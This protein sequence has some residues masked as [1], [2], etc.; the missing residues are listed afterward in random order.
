[1][2]KHLLF[3]LFSI[4]LIGFWL[5]SCDKTPTSDTVDPKTA[6]EKS[7]Q[8]YTEMENLLS[9]SNNFE[10]MNFSNV[11][12]LYSE[13]VT[14][15]PTNAAANFGAAFSH[16]LGTFGDTAIR[17]T[18]QRWDGVGINVP[19]SMV[20]FGIPT[21]S[22]D[23]TLPTEL[24][25]KNLVK[26]MQVATSDPPT[27]T[28]MQN[29]LRDRLLPRIN[30]AI[31]R[32]A[33]VETHADFELRISGKMQG[34]AGKKDLYL[35]L[36]EVY[37]M[38]AMLQGMKASVEQF[39]VFKF[40][41]SSYT[42]KA[43]VTALKQNNPDFFVLASDGMTRAQNV[44]GSLVAAVGKIRSGVTFLKNE[45]DNQNDDIIKRG[46]G[47][48]D[49]GDIDST[50]VY[51]NKI[52]TALTGTFTVELKNADS[53]HNN[54]TIQISLN[55]FYNNLPQN[56]KQEWFP[57]YSVDST[58]R[59]KL[60]IRWIGQDY[61]TFNF[62]DPTFSGLFPGMTNDKLKRLL[63]IDEA[64]AWR[65]SVQLYNGSGNLDN[66]AINIVVNG[67]TYFPKP[68]NYYWPGSNYRYF[69]FYIMDNNSMAVQQVNT[70][71]NGQPLSLQFYKKTPLVRAKFYD[72]INA[73]I[74]PASQNV[75]AQYSSNSIS[76]NL[77][78]WAYYKIERAIGTGSFV[79][80]DSIETS[81]Y[82]D[83]N[84]LSKTT[85]RYRAQRIINNYYEWSN[86][87]YAYRPSNYTNIVS[88]TTP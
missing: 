88:I 34:N 44:K 84:V 45:T 36:T 13:A 71:V 28:E 50:L 9:T 41:L 48:L 20:R 16:M 6:A 11:E 1:M 57:T 17:N 56:P 33:V 81:Y 51:L 64:F 26:I 25:G 65:L 19:S 12:K 2:K 42:T 29:L 5:S 63:Y 67:K 62:P 61:A 86:Y 87:F 4:S 38:D 76:L 40:Q 23:M 46:S 74:T 72:Y 24:L 70:T 10:S 8:A 78:S 14:A 77:Q 68:D 49:A 30:Y 32:L 54:H 66:S 21:G 43:A 37:I 52:E 85:Y 59:G 35:D 3:L 53:D 83:Y 58:S 55:S 22:S 31:A 69:D 18:L 7:A 27:I 73:D 82:S 39:L 47:G 75:S 15:D 80:K 79:N 60:T